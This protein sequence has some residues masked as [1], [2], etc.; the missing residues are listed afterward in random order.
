MNAHWLH[1]IQFS[2]IHSGTLTAI[3]RFS[4]AAVPHGIVPSS[5]PSLKADTGNLLPC[6]AVIGLNI[7]L[8]KYGSFTSSFLSSVAFAHSA[9]TSILTKEFIPLSTAS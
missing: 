9:G 7:F 8:M 2:N 1:C 4:Y 6:C 3:P 5:K